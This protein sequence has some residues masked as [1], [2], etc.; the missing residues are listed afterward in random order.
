VQRINYID[1][2]S[3]GGL[4]YPWR[5]KH[6]GRLMKIDPMDEDSLPICIHEKEGDRKFFVLK[7]PECSSLWRHISENRR[8]CPADERAY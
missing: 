7:K 6:I 2:G 5:Q 1:V 4:V 8:A 3:V